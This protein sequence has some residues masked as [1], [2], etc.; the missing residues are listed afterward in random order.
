MAGPTC[1]RIRTFRRNPAQRSRPLPIAV[2]LPIGLA[3]IMFTVGLRLTVDDFARLVEQPR[4]MLVGLGSQL[5][6]LPL[7]A[8]LI[9]SVHPLRPEFAVGLMV[10]AASPGGIT[11]NLL[12]LLAGGDVALAV[13]ITAVTNTVSILTLPLV[14]GAAT[15]LFLGTQSAV[16]IPVLPTIGGVLLTT[17]LPLAA[18]MLLRRVRPDA[19]DRLD[20]A[21]RRVAVAIFAAIVLGAFWSQAPQMVAHGAE[22]GPAVLALN[23]GS[24]ALAFLWA[25]LM[26]LDD[27]RATAIVLECG[28]QNA[29]MAITVCAVLLGN[30]AMVVP[31][32][33][34]ALVMNVTAV[35]VVLA[36]RRLRDPVCVPSSP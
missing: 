29:A 10:L 6:L 11:S 27:R 25:R 9:L 16:S 36:R 12:T 4:A 3:I 15:A 22:V 32:I 1:D 26:R 20:G 8:L 13:S 2:L 17:A 33:L 18:A 24:M 30:P 28:L 19:A 23:A 5:V 14:T 35:G 34:Y 31:A 21:L 7:L